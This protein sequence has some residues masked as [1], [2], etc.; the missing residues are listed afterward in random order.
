MPN[1]HK[2]HLKIITYK[3][4]YIMRFEYHDSY[5]YKNLENMT[6]AF[7]EYLKSGKPKYHIT[8]TFQSNVNQQEGVNALNALLSIVKREYFT[9][10][11]K[12]CLFG[13]S[14]K[15]TK[16]DK[17]FHFH[18]LVSDH[19]AFY[20]T[21]NIGKNL[22]AEFRK[23]ANR[24]TDFY[25]TNKGKKIIYHPIHPEIGIKFQYYYPESLEDYSMKE[26][27][28]THNLDF[29]SPLCE[30]GVYYADLSKDRPYRY[31]KHKL[32]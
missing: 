3:K 27:R 21:R 26:R 2:K 18:I 16:A 29:M 5:S 24:I 30:D 19:K 7:V 6:S 25:Y 4:E 31:I 17:S 12:E 11:R 8:I 22:E 9:R 14:F 13:Y 10:K 28:K 20:A 15:E 1:T 32:C 23:A